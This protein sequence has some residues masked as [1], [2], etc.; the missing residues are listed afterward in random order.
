MD[1]RILEIAS[2]TENN[3]IIKNFT[4]KSKNKNPLCGDEMEINLTVKN[5]K[6]QDFGYQCKSC[7]YCQ[8]SASL[9]SRKS[10]N[11]TLTKLNELVEFS[12]SFYENKEQTFSKEWT[13]FNKLFKQK[14]IARKECLLL[15][16]RALA[17]IF[18]KINE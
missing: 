5:N 13:S 7:I 15:P 18:K 16:F 11:Q 12:I 14:N 8:A 3:K 2:Q 1:L 4:H 9:L 17:K 10:I 6:I